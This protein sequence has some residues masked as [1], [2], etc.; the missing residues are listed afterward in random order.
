[1]FLSAIKLANLAVVALAMAQSATSNPLTSPYSTTSPITA[2]V[3]VQPERLHNSTVQNHAA[4]L[5]GSHKARASSGG[6]GLEKRETGDI[7]AH[8]QFVQEE[9]VCGDYGTVC[10][11]PWAYLWVDWYANGATSPSMSSSTPS[12]QCI[13]N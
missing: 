2:G 3:S 9:T 10:F 5:A 4:V 12:H 8:W 11:S 13:P 7:E 1:M 6:N